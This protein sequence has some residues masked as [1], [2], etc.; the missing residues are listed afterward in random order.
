MGGESLK[1][2]KENAGENYI[3]FKYK[4]YKVM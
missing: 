3:K 2:T 1:I 4:K